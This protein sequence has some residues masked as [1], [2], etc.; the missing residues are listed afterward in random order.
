MPKNRHMHSRQ[1]T[2]SS[3]SP[4]HKAIPMSL[5]TSEAAARTRY[6]ALT[7][8]AYLLSFFISGINYYLLNMNKERNYIYKA[9]TLSYLLGGGPLKWISIALTY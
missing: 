5:I 2:K 6:A 1:N 8:V 3:R 7:R 4:G 9:L